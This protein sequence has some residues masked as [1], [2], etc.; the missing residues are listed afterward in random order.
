MKEHEVVQ[1]T[2]HSC[3]TCGKILRTQEELDGVVN[4]L[5]LILPMAKG[6]TAEHQVGS[7]QRYIEVAEN[8]L[9]LLK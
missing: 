5:N 7:N 4:S 9:E 2:K 6:Y 3:I 1:L 8:T